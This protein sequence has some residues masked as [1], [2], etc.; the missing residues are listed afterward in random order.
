[1]KNFLWLFVFLGPLAATQ[2]IRY[3]TSVYVDT[4]YRWSD[5]GQSTLLLSEAAFMPR[6][7]LGDSSF[8]SFDLAIASNPTG[9]FSDFPTFDQKALQA[10]FFTSIGARLYVKGGLF[11]SLL[12][13][14]SLNLAKS[15][16]AS[17]SNLKKDY[18]SRKHLGIMLGYELSELIS[19]EFFFSN[20]EGQQRVQDSTAN[21]DYGFRFIGDSEDYFFAL[22]GV[23]NRQVSQSWEMLFDIYFG[24]RFNNL[25]Y[26]FDFIMSR[27]SA[28][29]WK[30]GLMGTLSHSLSSKWDLALRGEY[31][32]EELLNNDKYW[33]MATSLK[34]IFNHGFQMKLEYQLKHFESKG[35]QNQIA[36]SL[37]KTLDF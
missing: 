23:F 13:Y 24:G 25:N 6:V 4:H 32:S 33:A 30:M 35:L 9:T 14:E 29:D 3:R 37:L 12:G 22:G 8:I 1:M 11:D 20:P 16:F 26:A 19:A 21:F 10:Y 17:F 27:D 5:D 7:Y 28:K 15:D 2:E 36:L 18:L 31:L 34:Y